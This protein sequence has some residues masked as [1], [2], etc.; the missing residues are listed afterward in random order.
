MKVAVI[1]GG[2]AG[3]FAALS[4]KKHHSKAQVEILEKSTK[5]LSKVK[6]SGGGRCNVT[7][8]CF[9]AST[10]A[11]FY[12]R[13]SKQLKKSFSLFNT[14]HTVAWFKERGVQLKKEADN[15]MFPITDSSMTIINCFLNEC[16]KLGVIIK[17]E[18]DVEKI[19][20]VDNKIQLT[21]DGFDY[22]Y[23]KVIVA[24]GGSPKIEGLNWL[25]DLGHSTVN[26]LPSL[27]TFNMP[28]EEI[29]SLKGLSVKNAIVRIQGTKLVQDGPLLITH[30]GMSGP[31]VLKT[32]AWGA[33]DLA[34]LSY[35]FKAQINWVGISN[36]EEVRKL[37][38]RHCYSYDKK[39]IENSNPFEI[40]SRL[41]RYLL[42]KSE[43]KTNKINGDLGN[44]EK[45]K[46]IN[47][48]LNDVFVVKGKTTFKEEFV[49]CGGVSL[50]EVDM[51]TMQSK[52][53]SN[54]YFAGE[55][56]DVDG[57]TGGFNFQA[58]WTTGYI[59]GQ[60]KS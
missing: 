29:T 38:N 47:T 12:P 50:K 14:N 45:N 60:L 10:L 37:L 24:T 31:A 44:K 19:S 59:A 48:L 39:K 23:D 51:T 4:A 34:E 54:L 11:K 16:H 7:H 26:P 55:V 13:G 28:S 1:G 21:I 25:R 36:E 52:I 57:V 56:L 35:D 41:W 20:V 8:A 42:I 5:I 53:V 58:A 6:I 17:K 3:F 9:K 33:R 40:P 2:A 30:W 49:T 15:R 18:T 43:L 32:S 22:V 46:L 27:F